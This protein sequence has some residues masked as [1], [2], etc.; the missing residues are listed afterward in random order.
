M[1]SI[2]EPTAQ[3]LLVTADGCTQNEVRSAMPESLAL[4]RTQTTEAGVNLLHRIQD[5][6][7]V[8]L[9]A[10]IS[11]SKCIDFINAV[12]A[13]YPHIQC[14]LVCFDR[15]IAR[16]IEVKNSVI[17]MAA[18]QLPWQREQLVPLI[19]NLVGRARTRKEEL[20][21]LRAPIIDQQRKVRVTRMSMC[22]QAASDIGGS[23]RLVPY[24]EAALIV[25]EKDPGVDFNRF[26]VWEVDHSEA[27]RMAAVIAHVNQWVES[28]NN[29]LT[30][31]D[32]PEIFSVRG[33]KK[34][35]RDIDAQLMVLNGATSATP[36]HKDCCVLALLLSSDQQMLL[37]RN[38]Q[39]EWELNNGQGK[40]WP[41]DWLKHAMHAATVC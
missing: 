37:E 30:L 32:L 23:S 16:L 2:N 14:V 22:F 4:L 20:K 5:I 31:S 28:F 21:Y 24:F 34:I 3:I 13:F 26:D 29:G 11:T 1:L 41:D 38:G 19:A 15:D 12:Y 33:G 27:K 39:G 7:V 36:G 40:I 10:S 25:R 17:C 18:Y 35:V 6:E 8:F 9:D